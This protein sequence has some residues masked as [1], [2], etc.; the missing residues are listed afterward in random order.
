M[1]W[2]TVTGTATREFGAQ[3]DPPQALEG[4][5]PRQGCRAGRCTEAWG[6]L[7]SNPLLPGLSWVFFRLTDPDVALSQD[8]SVLSC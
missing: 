3:S 7:A 4:I 1:R 6:A 5:C 8:S 2:D